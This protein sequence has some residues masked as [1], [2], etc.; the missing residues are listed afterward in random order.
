MEKIKLLTKKEVS[1]MLRVSLDTIER[2]FLRTGV[3]T[4]Y[5]VGRRVF[6]SETEILHWLERQKPKKKTPRYE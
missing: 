4:R 3:F 5:T 1:A 2:R 6:L